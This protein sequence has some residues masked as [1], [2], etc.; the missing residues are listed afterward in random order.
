MT[1]GMLVAMVEQAAELTRPKRAV[2]VVHGMGGQK[3][4]ETLNELVSGLRHAYPKAVIDWDHLTEHPNREAAMDGQIHT[5]IPAVRIFL[6]EARSPARAVDAFEAYWADA[7]DRKAPVMSTLLWVWKAVGRVQWRILHLAVARSGGVFPWGVLWACL[8]FLGGVI[9]MAAGLRACWNYW[10]PAGG[11]VGTAAV[12]NTILFGL[13]IFK[14][15]EFLRTHLADVQI[16]VGHRKDT[17]GVTY[18]VKQEI[19][20]RVTR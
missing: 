13:I 12:V 15:L 5:R 11:S 9:S 20:D 18:A 2:V 1:C 16:Y 19:T 14:A 7:A 10:I 17:P 4:Y 8:L 6:D 3:P